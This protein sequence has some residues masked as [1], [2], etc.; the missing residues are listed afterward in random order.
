MF[1]LCQAIIG[2]WARAFVFPD[3]KIEADV[4]FCYYGREIRE[5]R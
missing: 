1:T 2:I 5:V 3:K 4:R